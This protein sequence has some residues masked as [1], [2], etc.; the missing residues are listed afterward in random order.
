MKVW[1]KSGKTGNQTN[2]RNMIEKKREFENSK[3]NPKFRKNPV[4]KPGTI[5]RIDH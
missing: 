5:F 4:R 2:F 1:K 3:K